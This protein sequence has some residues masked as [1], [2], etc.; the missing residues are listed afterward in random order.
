MLSSFP[1]L[2]QVFALPWYW[3]LVL[4]LLLGWLIEWILDAYVWR[5]RWHEDLVARIKELQE[6]LEAS[7]RRP[8]QPGEP[9]GTK[10]KQQPPQQEER[11][12]RVRLPAAAIGRRDPETAETA[13]VETA[14]SEDAKPADGLVPPSSGEAQPTEDP[15]QSDSEPPGAEAGLREAEPTAIADAPPVPTPTPSPPVAQPSVPIREVPPA[16]K[17]SA[18]DLTLVQGIGSSLTA[19]LQEAGI[20][21]FAQLAAMDTASLHRI[22]Q[23]PDW[24]RMNYE[25][26]ILQAEAFLAVP[27]VAAGAPGED[28]NRIEGITAK[29]AN[30]LRAAGVTSFMALA[31]SS[32]T[33][34]QE[35]VD[36]PSWK[37]ADYGLWREQARLIVAGD[38]KGLQRLQGKLRERAGDDLT[39][40][41][42]I[43]P[44]VSGALRSAGIKS[45]AQL[46]TTSQSDLGKVLGGAGLR[47]GQPKAWVAE[48]K[49]KMEQRAAVRG[50]KGRVEKKAPSGIPAQ[51]FG[52]IRGIGSVFQKKLRAAGIG[53]FAQL[54]TLS[55]H[56]L[57]DILRPEGWQEFDF[58]SWSE[59]ARRLTK[60][61]STVGASWNGIVPDDLTSIR[62][63]GSTS[64]RKLHDAGIYGFTDLASSSSRQL[65]AIIQP[66]HWQEV[67]FDS[68]IDQARDLAG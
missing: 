50:S 16:S 48:A 6:A 20:H 4:G 59:Q 33:R 12:R 46:A 29:Y 54:A 38:E 56:E 9:I 21:T 3:W 28:L 43:G 5:S 19:T 15:A 36:A 62:G 30:A 44:K 61:T 10:S 58:E 52:V 60:E 35:I 51:D 57:E 55:K 67:D 14:A 45:F 47:V 18:D 49:L 64:R 27:P 7:R 17:T 1:T 8:A 66:E 23:A 42:G 24:R 2:S 53:T 65:S 31:T 11:R 63:V 13:P 40:I 68:W 25:D 34:L 22:T 32:E 26:W 41:T 37:K 39:E